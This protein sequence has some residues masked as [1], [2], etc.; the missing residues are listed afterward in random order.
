M[1]RAA[2]VLL[3]VLL[4]LVAAPSAHAA[5]SFVGVLAD[6]RA[7]RFT[8]QAPTAISS[9]R[10]IAGLA[11]GDRVV[12]LAPGLALG[13]TGTLYRLDARAL[14]ATS[15]GIRV[16]LRGRGFSLV[17]SPGRAR[18][19]SDAGQD[20]TVDLMTRGM[21]PGS[22]LRLATGAPVRATVSALPDGRLVGVEPYRGTMVTETVPGS[23]VVA[24]APLRNERGDRLRFARHLGFAT[25]GGAGY[26]LSG[27]PERTFRRQARFFR[28]DL[29]SAGTR[30]EGGP[31]FR[32]E[33]V[34]IAPLGT[35]EDDRAA[36]RA[37]FASAPRRVSTRAL[38]REGGVRLRIR[39]SEGCFAY[40]ATAV[41]GR[42][43]LAAS[44]SRDT[45]GT[46][47]LSL[48]RLGRRELRLM[49]LGARRVNFRVTVRDWAGN[50]RIITR[51]FRLVR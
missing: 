9:P 5:E 24:E 28:V 13:R 26:L 22:G 6:G 3:L 16:A 12:A 32:R 49:R 40:G 4:A 46:V 14:R 30:G 8:D 2:P 20:L 36:P 33:V 17:A 31:F 51:R 41:G 15:T 48:P 27:F 37:R 25:A 23:G 11:R 45:A 29:S 10:P 18:I 42:P 7:V 43:N 44:A 35:V 1:T 38:R 39:C 21:T 34:A 19:L 47:T 50:Q